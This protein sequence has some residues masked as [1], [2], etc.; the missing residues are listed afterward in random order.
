[1]TGPA[2]RFNNFSA[3]DG[4]QFAVRIWDTPQ[5]IG[6]VVVIHGI[7]SHG[8]WYL[9][10]CRFL[11]QSGFEVHAIDRRGSGVNMAGR[12]DIDHYRTWLTDVETYLESLAPGLPTVLVGISWGGKIVAAIARLRPQLLAG[13]VMICPGLFAQQQV[14][15]WQGLVFKAAGAAGMRS[16]RIGI[17]LQDPSLF[18]DTLRWQTYIKNDPLTLRRMTIRF[19][20]ADLQL[21]RY[22]R[23]APGQIQIPMLFMLAGQDRIVD[24]KKTRD[25]FLG[26][27]ASDKTCIE[28]PD[29]GHTLEF[30][31][32]PS[33]YLE[34]LRHW[35]ERVT[36]AT[37]G[38]G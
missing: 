25:F 21:N 18:T 38:H 17:P 13:A 16:L 32:D 28:Y 35:V 1:M 30:E 36:C 20:L 31:L 7:V 33:S 26:I 23:A 24:N 19:V 14:K 34:D 5:P 27:G 11:G 22:A 12:G 9:G 37:G 15:W 4:Y 6:R 2:H 8:G 3:A 10:S 29:A